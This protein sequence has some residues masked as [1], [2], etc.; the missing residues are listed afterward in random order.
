MLLARGINC[1]LFQKSLK[2][3]A[4][5]ISVNNNV[6]EGKRNISKIAAAGETFIQYLSTSN[7]TTSLQF[8]MEEIHSITGLGWGSTFIASALLLRAVTSPTH[9]YAEKLLGKRIR[10]E[11]YVHNKVTEEMSKELKIDIVT[12]PSTNLSQLKTDNKRILDVTKR[13][14]AENVKQ[15]LIDNKLLPFRTICLKFSTVPIWVFSSFSIRNILQGGFTPA[16]PGALWITDLSLPDPYY[17]LPI[18]VALLTFLNIYSH[19]LLSPVS[20]NMF[21]KSV[22]TVVLI[23]VLIGVKFA[24]NLPAIFS[25]YWLSVASSGILEIALLRNPKFK[26]FIG[27]EK[28]PTDSKYPLTNLFKKN[29]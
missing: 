18:T 27:I 23:G 5:S 28:L 22:D 10:Y 14:I 20:S 11:N 29:K 17:I 4:P 7:L 19:R 8:C 2:Y 13:H 21:T 16:M 1:K 15:T 26:K 25:L 24:M 9:I 3:A 6:Y 12:D